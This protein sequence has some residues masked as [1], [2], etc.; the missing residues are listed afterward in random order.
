MALFKQFSGSVVDMNGSK[1][2][3]YRCRGYHKQSNTWSSWYV[4]SDTTGQYNMN[5]GDAAWLTQNGSI[6]TG[7]TVVLIFETLESTIATRSFCVYET[8]LVSAQDVYLQNVQLRMPVSPAV[9]NKWALVSPSFK[10]ELYVDSSNSSRVIYKARTRETVTVSES[11]TDEFSWVYSNATF[12]HVATLYNQELFSDRVGI[13]LALYDWNTG[14]YTDVPSKSFTSATSSDTGGYIAIK[15]KVTNVA[16][17]IST[18]TLYLQVRLNQPSAILTWLPEKPSIKDTLAITGTIV[19]IDNNMLNAVYSFDATTIATDTTSTYRW[20][21]GLD[22]AY[23]ADHVIAMVVRWTDGFDINTFTVSEP[24]EMANIPPTFSVVKKDSTKD[25]YI[26]LALNNLSDPDGATSNIRVKWDLEFVT[27]LA[28]DYTSIYATTY[29]D[30]PNPRYI[31]LP[32]T[33][34][35]NYKMVATAIDEAGGETSNYVEFTIEQTVDTS[36]VSTSRSV[37]W[38]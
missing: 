16:G 38:E 19:A 24:L 15:V 33:T 34:V 36:S 7:D 3:S 31:D 25:G 32:L 14:I 20:Q 10:G 27:P 30:A 17:L 35:G 8:K 4:S 2:T 23:R 22:S 5:M 21:Q 18:D 9:K 6:S 1:I 11:F 37:E 28:T 13:K 26:R 29:P 12:K